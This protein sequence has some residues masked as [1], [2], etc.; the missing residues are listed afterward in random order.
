MRDCAARSKV[1]ASRSGCWY[2]AVSGRDEASGRLCVGTRPTATSFETSQVNV[3]TVSPSP[4]F[5][6]RSSASTTTS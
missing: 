3:S 5:I 6:A 4:R 2:L 1:L